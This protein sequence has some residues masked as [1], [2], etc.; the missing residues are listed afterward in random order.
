MPDLSQRIERI[1]RRGWRVHIEDGMPHR[2][3]LAVQAQ[4]PKAH[5]YIHVALPIAE[6]VERL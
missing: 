5:P 3:E 6:S 4:H 1:K 2:G